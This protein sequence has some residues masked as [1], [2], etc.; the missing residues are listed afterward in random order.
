MTG[1]A[2]FPHGIVLIDARLGLFAMTRGARFVE[3]RH[4]QAGLGSLH[5]VRTVRVVA[6]DAIHPPLRDRVMIGKV[7][8]RVNLDM[9]SQARLRITAW[10]DNER[11]IAAGGDVPAAGTVAGFTAGLILHSRVRNVD[12]AVRTGSE[13]SR[14]IRVTLVASLVAGEAG[15]F[16]HRRCHDG[17]LNGGAR[18]EDDG[19][20]RPGHTRTQPPSA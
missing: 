10:I 4:G 1:R 8:L 11:A 16:N 13:L 9:A 19:G 5:D 14:V 7:D 2:A 15:A 12:A 18:T 17:A 3:S 20:Q 6:L